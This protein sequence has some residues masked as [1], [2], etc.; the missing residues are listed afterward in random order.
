MLFSIKT[1]ALAATLVLATVT[2]SFAAK[3]DDDTKLLDSPHKWADVVADV[4]EGDHVKILNC[5]YGKYCYV[6]IDGDKGYV[7]KDAIDF[8]NKYDGDTDVKFCF[9]GPLGYVCASS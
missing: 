8:G 6:K 9:S 4:D 2:G 5:G 3:L 1:A 7:R